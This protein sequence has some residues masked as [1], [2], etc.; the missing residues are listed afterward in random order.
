MEK[1]NRKDSE[2]GKEILELVLAD[3]LLS[4]YAMSRSFKKYIFLFKTQKRFYLIR[5]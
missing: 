1:K 5:Y 4:M 3:F 2:R